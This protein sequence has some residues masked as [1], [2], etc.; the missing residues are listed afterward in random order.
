MTLSREKQ[1]RQ[2]SVGRAGTRRNVKSQK[3]ASHQLFEKA[4]DLGTTSWRTSKKFIILRAVFWQRG[5]LLICSFEPPDF[6][7]YCHQT[8]SHFLWRNGCRE[9]ASMIIPIKILCSK[10]LE[11]HDCRLWQY[12]L[13]FDHSELNEGQGPKGLDPAQNTDIGRKPHSVAD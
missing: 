7:G 1:C 2:A 10:N 6:R 9:K 5:F 4:H 13:G 11:H 3:F 12:F 8:F